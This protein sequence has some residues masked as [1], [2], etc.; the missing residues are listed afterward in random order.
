MSDI[1]TVSVGYDISDEVLCSLDIP[2]CS[3]RPET[4]VNKDSL[5]SKGSTVVFPPLARVKCKVSKTEPQSDVSSN[6]LS[7]VFN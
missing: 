3:T 2:D 4:N 5:D 1:W 6:V 7:P